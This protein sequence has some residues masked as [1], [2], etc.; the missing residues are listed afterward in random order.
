M[1]KFLFTLAALLMVTSINAE[2]YFYIEDFQIP[3]GTPA[4]TNFSVPVKAHFDKYVSAWQCDL[5]LPEGLTLRGVRAGADMTLSYTDD[6]GDPKTVTPDISRQG[7]RFIVAVMVGDYDEDGNLY[8]VAKWAPGDY[9]EMLQ[10]VFR[11]D[12]TFQGGT[13]GLHTEFSCGEDTRPE[14]SANRANAAETPAVDPTGTIEFEQTTPDLP[15]QIVIGDPVAATGQFSV[16]YLP[17]DYEGDYTMT[18][19]INGEEA[20]ALS[21]GVYQAVEGE[22]VVV[23]TISA[24]GYNDLTGDKTFEWHAPTYAPA[25]TFS[26]DPDTYTMTAT[27]EDHEVELYANGTKVANPYK[28]EQTDVDQEITFSAITLKND[29]DNNSAETFYAANPVIVPAKVVVTPPAKPTYSTDMDNEFFYITFALA[30][31]AEEG[32][33]L[34]IYDEEGQEVAENPVKIARPD[35]DE[36]ADPVYARYS[37][38]AVKDDATS[39]TLYV[40]ELV[41]QKAEPV[42]GPVDLKGTLTIGEADETGKFTVTY[43]GEEEVTIT[44]DQDFEIVRNAANTYQLPEYGTYHVK[45]TA[46]AKADGYNDLVA[47]GDVTWTKP[48][49]PA[50]T[51]APEVVTTPGDASYSFTGQVKAGDPEAE[52][53]IY[54]ITVD[55]TT[56]EEVRNLVGNPYVVARTAEDQHIKIAV[57]AHIDGQTDGEVVMTVD[58][59][60]LPEQPATG[61]D[62]LMNGKTV[63]AVRYFN[64]AGQEMQEANGVT[65]VVTTYTDGTTSAVKVMK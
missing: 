13:L 20:E 48:A 43:E 4:N 7:N 34:V 39:E 55:E 22:N 17:G 44:I 40:N 49:E 8:G 3:E 1:K 31:D 32:T 56:G 47:E 29:E 41:P 63:A 64:M 38:V 61:V 35:Y 42:V 57:V 37:A 52:V 60:K 18:V 33:E 9:N 45:A 59:P 54:V 10:L 28:V 50:Q 14:I 6:L 53:S 46:K 19:T 23:V 21:D 65:I 5:T 12:D 36:T 27:C 15:G 30:E 58:V 26:W 62:E 16:M 24:N 11:Y 2:C 51:A 25:P